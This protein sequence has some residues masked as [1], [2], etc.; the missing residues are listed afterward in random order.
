MNKKRIL[1]SVIVIPIVF[2]F[3]LA[4]G[5]P[6]FVFLSTLVIA[7]LL[8]FFN[9]CSMERV[10]TSR[11]WGGLSTF[12]LLLNA[13]LV[14][15][16]SGV[17]LNDDFTSLIITLLV[18]GQLII[19]LIKSD[20]KNALINV[21]VTMMGV[22][23]VGW[24]A[25]HALLLREVR[26]YGFEYFLIACVVTWVSDSGAYFVGRRLGKIT[27]HAA[28][29][30]K[31]F[32]GALGSVILGAVSMYVL[33]FALRLSFIK[34]WQSLTLGAITGGA[35]VIGDLAE[36]LIKRNLNQKDSGVFLPGHG[37]VLDR[38]DSLLFTVPLIYYFVRYFIK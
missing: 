24:L 9:M 25:M 11:W 1:S 21:S 26:P 3:V 36:S 27:L 16:G 35:A 19:L 29:P 8:E 5:F 17:S 14:V 22:M 33:V 12:A 4:G 2:L 13:Y 6:F 28:S 23:Y 18:I 32:A 38:I 30:N 15:G 31:S 34:A 7:A 37:G 10:P 20:L